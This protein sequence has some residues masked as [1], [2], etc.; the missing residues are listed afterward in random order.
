MKN[1]KKISEC[2]RNLAEIHL[3]YEKFEKPAGVEVEISAENYFVKKM[4]LSANKKILQ[5]NDFITIKNIPEKIF[6]YVV[7]GHK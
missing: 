3:N 7:S 1:L 6:E 2:G 4:K 5:Y